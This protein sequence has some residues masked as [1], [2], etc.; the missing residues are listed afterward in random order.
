MIKQIFG[1]PVFIESIN[2]DLYKKKEI[3]KD[4]EYNYKKDNTRNNWE[5]SDTI[6]K[7][8]LHHAYNDWNNIKFKS[9]NFTSLIPVYKKSISNFFE[10]FSFKKTLNFKFNITNYTCMTSNQYMK[11]HY[12]PDSDFTAVHYIKFN[13]KIHKPT[14]YENSNISSQFIKALRPKL[15]NLVDISDIKNSWFF[16]NYSFDIKEDDICI[17]P[18]F[19][20]HSVPI[21]DTK[22]K[23]NDKRITVVL[24]ISVE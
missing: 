12:H 8:N 24:N 23:Q 14:L 16:E 7:S 21:Q 19:L 5:S 2:K 3:I 22:L 6:K 20:F 15:N 9:I 11:S 17:T 13:E 18:S 10:N 1:F 4:I